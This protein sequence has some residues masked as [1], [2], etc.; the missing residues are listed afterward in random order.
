MFFQ[1]KKSSAVVSDFSLRAQ[2][3]SMPCKGF[4]KT[5]QA[6]GHQ[7]LGKGQGI[8]DAQKIP[9]FT[10]KRIFRP[11]A[12]AKPANAERWLN[13]VIDSAMISLPN[14]VLSE[15]SKFPRVD[16]A[17]ADQ[18]GTSVLNLMSDYEHLAATHAAYHLTDAVNSAMNRDWGPAARQF[19]DQKISEMAQKLILQKLDGMLNPKQLNALVE[20]AWP[21]GAVKPEGAVGQKERFALFQ[22]T[23]SLLGHVLTQTSLTDDFTGFYESVIDDFKVA[24]NPYTRVANEWAD[25]SNPYQQMLSELSN[26][27]LPRLKQSYLNLTGAVESGLKAFYQA[28]DQHVK[29]EIPPYGQ[30][31]SKVSGLVSAANGSN[32]QETSTMAMQWLDT[33]RAKFK[34]IIDQALHG[35]DSKSRGA[36]ITLIVA[37]HLQQLG[38]PATS[39]ARNL[40]AIQSA[41]GQ[42]DSDR[43]NARQIGDGRLGFSEK[44]WLVQ[45][46]LT[47]VRNT[48]QR[49]G[50]ADVR[51]AYSDNRSGYATKDTGMQRHIAKV[52]GAEMLQDLAPMHRNFVLSALADYGQGVTSFLKAKGVKVRTQ[53]EG[54]GLSDK[55]QRPFKEVYSHYTRAETQKPIQ[56]TAKRQAEKI[57]SNPAT[58][59]MI[60]YE[61]ENLSL[62]HFSSQGNQVVMS[63][64]FSSGGEYVAA[65]ELGHALDFSLSKDGRHWFSTQEPSLIQEYQQNVKNHDGL[66]VYGQSHL[67]ETFAESM[68]AF[69]QQHGAGS[70]YENWQGHNDLFSKE[71]LQAHQPVMS[72]FA[73]EVIRNPEKLERAVFVARDRHP[74]ESGA[75]KKMFQSTRTP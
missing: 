9:N 58:A 21:I 72:R 54:K 52:A 44:K 50:V 42:I 70:S 33:E 23:D 13:K 36:L 49:Y 28:Y 27:P 57:F 39:Q 17:L 8:A 3:N 64:L 38:N 19:A 31:F 74:A 2:N 41:E 66:T 18:Y 26:I 62:P 29:N 73:D 5:T 15:M 45:S 46:A 59:N 65:H 32:G 48:I 51:Q 43:L 4:A 35:L 71:N 60:A 22:L 1:I 7:L 24:D 12:W 6:L 16:H 53:E 34:D 40:P 14:K 68:A 11:V 10:L 61:A 25:D 47:G 30:T 56:L 67:L 37:P 20:L 55:P 69:L 63:R 75:E